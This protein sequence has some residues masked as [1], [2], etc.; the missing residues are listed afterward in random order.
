M[1]RKGDIQ[2]AKNYLNEDEID[3]LNRLTVIFL[4]SAE[5]RV[6]SKKDLTLDFWRK[7]VAALLELKDYLTLFLGRITRL[8]I[9]MTLATEIINLYN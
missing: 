6:K 5:L 3:S 7:N 4:E 8:P 2:I 1:V 9:K